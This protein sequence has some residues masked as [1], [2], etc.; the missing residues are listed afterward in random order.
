MCLVCVWWVSGLEKRNTHTY[1]IVDDDQDDGDDVSPAAGLYNNSKK[2]H[3]RSR[4]FS[5]YMF[6]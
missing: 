1:A 2:K 4:N 3:S 5:L 6:I